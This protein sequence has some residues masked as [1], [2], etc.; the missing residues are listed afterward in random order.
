[1]NWLNWLFWGGLATLAQM[2]F[3]AATQAL[4]LT[5]MSLPYMLGTMFTEG[6]SKAK[7][8]GFGLHFMNGLLVT[9][10]Y[11][12]TFHYWGEP[13]WWRGAIIGFAQ[14]M[15]VLL[16]IMPLLPEIHPRMA[17]ERYGPAAMRQLEPPGSMALNYGPKTPIA[18]ILSHMI[19]GC[20]IGNFCRV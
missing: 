14:A 8:A 6:R 13:T 3:E 20:I 10:V 9:L 17:S 11:V 5:R 15:F 4:R 18:I 7:I 1:M 19:F 2:V 12:V 16:V